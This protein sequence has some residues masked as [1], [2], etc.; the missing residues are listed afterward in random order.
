MLSDAL[1]QTVT[2]FS[3]EEDTELGENSSVCVF[4]SIPVA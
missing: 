1:F 2:L 4:T 3:E